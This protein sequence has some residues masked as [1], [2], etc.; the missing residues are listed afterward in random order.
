[1]PFHPFI[2]LKQ[3][4]MESNILA[5]LSSF[6]AWKRVNALQ[7]LAT[8]TAFPPETA[9]MNLHV[10][11]FFSYNG[12]GWSP[13]RIAY[14]MKQLG[15]YGSA[16]CDFDVLQGVE[17]FL[18]AGDLL[19]LRTA[20]SFESRVFFSEYA[21]Q[22]INSPGEPGVFYFMGSGFVKAP[23]D[24]SKAAQ[25][26]ELLLEQSH[27][28]NR[29]LI[30]RVNAALPAAKLDY[31]RDVLPLT[32]DKNATERH[33]VRAY[34]DQAIKEQGSPEAAAAFW[35]KVFG[36][37]EAE[38]AAKSPNAMNDYLHSK[39]M[40][41]GGLGYTQ[42][43]KD[44]FP[45]IEQVIELIREC[46]ALPNAAWL[47][48]SLPGEADPKAQL[49]CLVAKGLEMVNI[50]P[51]RNWNFKD[52]AKAAVRVQALNEYI[53]AAQAL[54]LP[55]IVGT[56]CNKPGQRK[57]DDFK[58]P[59]LAPHLD[60]FTFGANV[61][62][63]HTRLLRYADYSYSD[64]QAKADFPT[65]KARNDFFAAV[66]ALPPPPP[67]TIALLTNRDDAANFDYIKK[68]ATAGYWLEG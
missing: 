16:L 54:D 58:A 14:E 22:E 8:I 61:L 62:F 49:E 11:S 50:I 9:A 5:Q 44:T 68:S 10:H 20:A 27:R 17:E 18:T 24:G 35:A 66:G 41:K 67:T 26:F 12:E 1:I 34:Y 60:T 52:P 32:P 30:A 2:H 15:L 31:E 36:A 55:I 4:T 43:T 37:D 46:R 47:D 56:E 21:D 45:P 65:R 19:G 28:R 51:D 25:G 57:V 29:E 63:G 42:P 13:S 6:D 38:L 48:G 59:A 33:I 53:A 64:A 7:T 3:I 39:L 40:K 23:A